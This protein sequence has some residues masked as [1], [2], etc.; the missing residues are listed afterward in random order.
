[1]FGGLRLVLALM[2]MIGHLVGQHDF[3]HFGCYAVRGFFILSG[4]LMTSGLNEIYNFEARRFWTNRLLRLLPSYYVVCLVTLL[5]LI[6]APISAAQFAPYWHP[7]MLRDAITNVFLLPLDHAEPHYRLV[8][9]S[10]SLAIEIEMYLLLFVFVARRENY[11][12]I[13]LGLGVLYHACCIY[14]QL[15]FE[16]RYFPAPAACLPFS[17]GALA[18]FWMKRNFINISPS[19]A[20]FA[21]LLW[22][23][24]VLAG[25]YVLGDAYTYGPGYYLGMGL[26]V[27]AVAGLAQAKATAVVSK[28]D[29]ALGEI[30]YPIFLL[31]WLAGFVTAFV[32]MHGALR[33]WPLFLATLPTT[34]VLSVALAILN[35]K[36]IEPLRMRIR[37]GT[38]LDQ[39]IFAANCPA[40][41]G[42]IT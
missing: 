23:A 37:S 31:H 14:Y 5:A 18:Y 1:M 40:G 25:G 22:F 24:N 19:V 7:D 3:E 34:F 17:L 38:E 33:G 11:A 8:P 10:W 28:L 42:S 32:F 36:L 15:G 4:F 20:V 6:V 9:P 13:G 26:F 2:V 12:L 29:G 27:V 35:N 39:P 30:A 41:A 21:V 16:Y